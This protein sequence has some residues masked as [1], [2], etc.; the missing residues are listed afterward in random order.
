DR[1]EKRASLEMGIAAATGISSGAVYDVPRLLMPEI[2][3]WAVTELTRT[4]LVGQEIFEGELCYRIKGFDL[5]GD[6]NEVW[7]NQRDFLIRKI[8]ADSTAGAYSTTEEEIH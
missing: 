4:A 2:D 7:I 1:Y 5:D 3:G 8:T 6:L